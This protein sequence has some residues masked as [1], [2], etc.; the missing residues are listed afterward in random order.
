METTELS[1]VKAE[2]D[3][4]VAEAVDLGPADMSRICAIDIKVLKIGDIYNDDFDIGQAVLHASRKI[5][6]HIRSIE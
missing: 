2:L 6:N 3:A 4:L 5:D 1:R